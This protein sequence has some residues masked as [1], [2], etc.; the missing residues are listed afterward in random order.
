MRRKTMAATTQNPS[1][2]E[3]VNTMKIAAEAL[4]YA[5]DCLEEISKN[6]PMGPH[7]TWERG[8]NAA[9]SYNVDFGGTGSDFDAAEDIYA[10]VI[11]SETIG[12]DARGDE[13]IP[14][15]RERANNL[16]K[17]A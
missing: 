9:D 11:Y 5:A 7:Y 13:S 8:F 17:V 2:T 1:D 4:I 10:E 14:K 12:S 15:I 3:E 6:D 16:L